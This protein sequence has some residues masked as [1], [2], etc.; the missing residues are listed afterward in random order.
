MSKLVLPLILLFT[1][2]IIATQADELGELKFV[3]Q[4]TRH[5]AR[6]PSSGKPQG[7]TITKDDWKIRFGDLTQVGERQHY[8]LGLKNYK[9]YQSIGFLSKD[10]DPTEISVMSTDFNRTMMSAA[11]EVVGY[12]PFY[13]L[14]NLTTQEQV[15]AKTPF[16]FKGQIDAIKNL[17]ESTIPFGYT[18]IPIHV[19]TTDAMMRGMDADICPYQVELRK[20]YTTTNEWSEINKKYQDVL[21]PEMV[22]K[23]NATNST[24]TW[25]SAYP[26]IDN[27]YSAWFDQMEITNPLTLPAQDQVDMILRDGLY[28]GFYGL[29]LA[30]RLASSR[31]INFIRTTIERKIDAIINKMAHIDYYSDLKFLYTSAHDST[32]SALLSGLQHKQDEQV[33][34]ASY[35]I[36]EVYQK[37]LSKGDSFDDFTVRILYNGKEVTLGGNSTCKSA[38]CDFLAFKDFMQ[39]REYD[40]DINKICFD[41]HNKKDTNQAGK[42]WTIVLFVTIGFIVVSIILYFII[43]KARGNN[44]DKAGVD[45]SY[46]TE[47]LKPELN[48][49]STSQTRV[50]TD[51]DSD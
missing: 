36:A 35:V 7:S 26:Y 9:Y 23:W 30:V 44:D 3:Y 16:E 18:P 32:I 12:Y 39:S 24:L 6:A 28:E 33:Y 11:S 48:V 1:F 38:N 50:V 37:P 15:Y 17:K 13:K 51:D 41:N 42:D 19:G 46:D 21:F 25:T 5:G 45:A 4:L 49:T 29:D 2:A 31:L 10:Y 43:L 22:S 47:K 27:Y 34:F 8:L 14:K 40:G 20:Q